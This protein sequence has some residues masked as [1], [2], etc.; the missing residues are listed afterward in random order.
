MSQGAIRITYDGG[1]AS[2]HAID[3][4]LLG[5]SLQGIGRLVSDCL[6]IFAFERLPRRKEAVP[7]HLK[8]KEPKAGS[9]DL[10]GFYNEASTAL[11]I[12]VPIITQI[13][14]DI[15]SHYVTAVID[16]FRGKDEAVEIAI[17]KMAEMHKASLDAMTESQR[18]AHE[19]VDRAD[20]RRHE[21]A[22]GLQ[23]VLRAAISASGQAAADYVAPVGRSVDTAKFVSGGADPVIVDSDD[24]EA[25]RNS[26]KLDWTSIEEFSVRTDGFRFH[27]S[28]LSVENP[29]GGFLMAEVD[30]EL[31]NDEDNPYTVAAAKR[32]RI[33]VKGKIGRKG[34]RIARIKIY[35]FVRALDD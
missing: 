33:L 27:T 17:Q 6:F 14:P 28:G 31:F 9:V 8:V 34:E 16:K 26:Q 19:A 21:E 18:M 35:E 2:Q 22:M 3:A 20:Q 15:V 25:I 24:A 13:G 29:D 30:D 11:A 23:D 12:G 4:R 10:A 5:Q 7:L 32:G 1:D